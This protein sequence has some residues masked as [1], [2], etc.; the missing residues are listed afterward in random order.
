MHVLFV[1]N[2]KKITKEIILFLIQKVEKLSVK[3]YKYYVL[4]VI[5]KNQHFKYILLKK[6]KRKEK[7][8]NSLAIQLTNIYF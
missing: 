4:I 2:K 7:E 5:N 1:K 8:K 3:I 6:K